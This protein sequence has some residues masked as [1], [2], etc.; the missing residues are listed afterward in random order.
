MVDEERFM[1]FVTFKS[2]VVKGMEI[3]STLQVINNFVGLELLPK[4]EKF[5]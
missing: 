2:P 1:G 5:F 4:F 3:L